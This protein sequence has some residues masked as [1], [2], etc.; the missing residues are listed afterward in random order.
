RTDAA[1]R[2]AAEL[3]LSFRTAREGTE[4]A[5]ALLADLV[6]A[7]RLTPVFDVATLRALPGADYVIDCRLIEKATGN[8]L[9]TF[10]QKLTKFAL[11]LPRRFS[12]ERTTHSF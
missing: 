11:E 9:G 2:E 7:H 12:A 1:T 4:I 5:S 10:Q 3:H 8:T 6:E